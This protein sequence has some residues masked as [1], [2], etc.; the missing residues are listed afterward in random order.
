M[1]EPEDAVAQAIRFARSGDFDTI[2]V[3]GDSPGS[4]RVAAAIRA[5]LRE[6]GITTGHL[7]R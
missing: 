5:G 7:R 4:E 3:H 6:A 1:L 2:C